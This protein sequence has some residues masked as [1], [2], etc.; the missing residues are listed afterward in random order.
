MSPEANEQGLGS[1][2]RPG[3][4]SVCSELTDC[5]AVQAALPTPL[6]RTCQCALGA[7][8]R[9]GHIDSSQQFSKEGTLIVRLVQMGKRVQEV[10]TLLSTVGCRVSMGALHLATYGSRSN[11]GEARAGFYSRCVGSFVHLE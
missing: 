2:G 9:A 10:R 7:G 11:P 4:S 5:W 8:P 1:A 3:L 6:C